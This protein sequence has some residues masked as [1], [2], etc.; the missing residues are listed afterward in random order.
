MEQQWFDREVVEELYRE[1]DKYHVIFQSIYHS[2]G[3]DIEISRYNGISFSAS[4]LRLV[5]KLQQVSF[6]IREERS[7]H[8][9]LE[10]FK[11]LTEA[12]NDPEVLIVECNYFF[13]QAYISFIH[14]EIDN[15]FDGELLDPRVEESF[16]A[17]AKL[18]IDLAEFYGGQSTGYKHTQRTVDYQYEYIEKQKDNLYGLLY[19]LGELSNVSSRDELIIEIVRSIKE[20]YYQMDA[21][22]NEDTFSNLY[23]YFGYLNY[24]GSDHLLS[25]T[26]FDEL[27]DDIQC[28]IDCLALPD[29]VLL[30]GDDIH[31]IVD[32]GDMEEIDD[33]SDLNKVIAESTEFNRLKSEIRTEF[34]KDV[35]EYFPE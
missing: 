20:K 25:Q 18:S 10:G 15:I 12:V 2:S 11:E 21:L 31:N 9:L 35:P 24:H 28:E 3:R 33:W 30:L 8:S 4:E 19:S 5:F 32:D 13:I 7:A 14:H 16:I 34:F 17:L 23:E 1:H 6:A 26:A 22:D 29:L 27:W